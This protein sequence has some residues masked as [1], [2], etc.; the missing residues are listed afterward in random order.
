M[1]K[2]TVAAGDDPDDK[3]L[4]VLID[5]EDRVSFKRA[6]GKIPLADPNGSVRT[7]IR[8]AARTVQQQMGIP[9][10][11]DGPE[12]RKV[13]VGPG[14]NPLFIDNKVITSR[15][16]LITFI[17]KFLLES[18]AKFANT[19]FL[20]VSIFQL[21]PEISTTDG[22][23]F[24][25]FPLSVVIFLEAILAGLEDRQRHKDDA[26]ANNSKCV[27]VEDGKAITK[28]WLDVRVGDII[29]IRNREPICADCLVLSASDTPPAAV[30]YVETKS[31]DGETNLKLR[32]GLVEMAE[33][34]DRLKNDPDV[35]RIAQQAG[36]LP[37]DRAVCMIKG[38]VTSEAPN[39]HID[40][41]VGAATLYVDGTASSGQQAVPLAPKNILLRG[42][43]V[44]ST[45]YVYGLVVNT[46]HETKVFQSMI[47]PR[48]KRSTLD[49][50]VQYLLMGFL[51]II[52]FLSFLG[53]GLAGIWY[54]ESTWDDLY[55]PQVWD[56]R[57][58]FIRSFTF[59]LLIANMIPISLYV[60]MKVIRFCQ[61]FFIYWDVEMI[62]SGE[63]P[64]TGEKFSHP[65]K[66]RSM[67]VNDS[68]GQISYLFSDKTG[69]LTNNVMEFRKLSVGGK[70]YGIG[71]T[72]IGV[73]AFEKDGKD[74]EAKAAKELLRK[75]EK[76]PHPRFVNFIDDDFT[77]L[78]LS[79][80][81]QDVD[82][83]LT[84]LAICHEVLIETIRDD[85]GKDTGEQRLS[86]SSPDDQAL[87]VAATQMGYRFAGRGDGGRT[88]LVEI[89]N[90]SNYIGNRKQYESAV[91]NGES[92]EQKPPKG[93][94]IAFEMLET[95]EFTSTRKRMSVIVRDPRTG[96][97]KLM[98]KGADSEVFKRLSKAQQGT[99]LATTTNDQITSFAND[100]LRTLTV[101]WKEIDANT[102]KQWSAQ[103]KAASSNLVEMEKRKNKEDNRIDDLMDEIESDLTLL[104]ATAIED[105]LQELVPETVKI[106]AEAGIK[107]WVLT[108][109]KEETAINI[110]W[111]C[112]LIDHSMR[113]IVINSSSAHDEASMGQVLN[114]YCNDLQL[115]VD[116]NQI[117]I[118]SGERLALVID[119]TALKFALS[120]D[121][122]IML[123]RLACR[124]SAVV[125][126]RVSPKQKGEVVMLVRKNLK[127]AKTL[128]IGDGAND[129]GMI[130]AAHVG[131]G[132]SGLEGMQAVNAAD[133]ALGR[134]YFLRRLLLLHGRNNYRRTAKL[135]IL[136][137]YKNIF[138]ILAQ[139]I[140]SSANGYSG[141]KFYFQWS[142]EGFNLFWTNLPVLLLGIYDKDL[143]DRYLLNV[144]Q[145]YDLGL[146]SRLF[147][148]L[149]FWAYIINAIF[150]A[151]VIYVILIYTYSVPY[152]GDI[153]L[154]GCFL[155]S[156][157]IIVSN[158]KIA[159]ET[160]MW[161]TISVVS[162]IISNALWPAA[163]AFFQAPFS[164]NLTQ[165]SSW[166]FQGIYSKM[167]SYAATYAVGMLMIVA[168]LIR[169][170]AW[171]IL[172]RELKPE[173]RHILM[174]HAKVS[175]RSFNDQ[176]PLDPTVEFPSYPGYTGP[177]ES[178]K[179]LLGVGKGKVEI[180]TD[181]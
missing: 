9:T 112:Q 140:W 128:G 71:T 88:V 158:L 65:A 110:A 58:F 24:S 81:S 50:T 103:Y 43:V 130:Q 7:S 100:G 160:G 135:V 40:K 4:H 173:L 16:N 68:L 156:I 5:D 26:L 161:T 97:V 146:N 27:V 67:D 17:P 72:I 94:L 148:A 22:V 1:K 134:F 33:A 90:P 150:H 120:K 15:Y 14:A 2:T 59:F 166:E 127:R 114:K 32:Q 144:P 139:I 93:N 179:Y 29:K 109:D 157:V 99:S 121:N 56:I 66:V 28:K 96:V 116:P 172:V 64:L 164:F 168:L 176:G 155:M 149:T 12:G 106:L 133:F 87:V 95:L 129:V 111:A 92:M 122:H 53:G 52:I 84:T 23:P 82:N 178:T 55:V 180:D 131:V 159:L 30:C 163:A 70:A 74:K 177:R 153:W 136:I 41:Y 77:S 108:G 57:A 171:K 105:K 152:E 20:I 78:L 142:V 39:P 11:Q 125:A 118:G 83:F 48:N 69:T 31:L 18:F 49:V 175:G 137:L 37:H 89:G 138:M 45:D 73:A 174:E 6:L 80:S 62:H 115:N 181:V 145:L 21:I 141:Q 25:L 102:Y 34:I 36:Q 132:I 124:C 167:I 86:A 60:S 46:G 147:N 98:C 13:I 143:P 47:K 51:A 107:I 165:R 10:P 35:I 3:R 91:E 126:C 85:E 154:Y 101:A 63:D 117:E 75:M 119:G 169:D 38:F 44:R 61:S 170:F 42:C 54:S 151:S 162:W 76:L 113:R 79:K 104:G 19:Y 123:L 8:A